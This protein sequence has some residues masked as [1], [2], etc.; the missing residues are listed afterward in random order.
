MSIWKK[1][2]IDFNCKKCGN[3]KTLPQ[4]KKKECRKPQC[5]GEMLMVNGPGGLIL[6]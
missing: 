6:W 4:P 3:S 5:N 2:N 1:E